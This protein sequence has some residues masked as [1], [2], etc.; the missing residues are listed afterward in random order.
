MKKLIAIDC[1]NGFT[2]SSVNGI[3]SIEPT[4]YAVTRIQPSGKRRGLS[5]DG[6]ELKIFGDDAVKSPYLLRQAV[7]ETERYTSEEYTDIVVAMVSRHTETDLKTDLVLG[8][9]SHHFASC[10]DT[11]RK[12]FENRRFTLTGDKNIVIEIENV[13]V[14]P[15]PLGTYV[16][17]AQASDRTLVVDGGHGTIDFS[18]FQH[19]ELLVQDSINRGMRFVYVE[20]VVAL[21][22]R[23][24]NAE[25][26]ALDIPDILANGLRY[27][28]EVIKVV[29]DEIKQIFENHFDFVCERIRSEYG[30]Y[31]AFD[32]IIFTGGM[33][34]AYKL[35]I[36]SSGVQQFRIADQPSTANV[37]G[38][39]LLGGVLNG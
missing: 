14:F 15:Q 21:K 24:P 6:H 25:I 9:P 19:S 35:V 27:R 7:G 17:S 5:I 1:G 4:V 31:D 28:G 13:C 16:V 18:T 37:R 22:R 39:E 3:V 32:K 12:T 8:L 34:E 26:T 10:R 23:F 2:K 33:A 30:S 20:I 29:D 11:L 36:L 38:F